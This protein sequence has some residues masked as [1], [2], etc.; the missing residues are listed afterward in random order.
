MAARYRAEKF[1]AYFQAFTNT[2]ASCDVLRERY[3]QALEDSEIV[4]LAIGTRP[5]CVDEAKL[6]LIEAYTATHM[7]W[8]EYGLQSSHNRTLE[9]INRGHNFEDFVRAV[10]MTQGRNILICAHIILGLPGESKTDVLDT[11]RALS[12]LGIDGIKIHSLYILKETP[13][14]QLL[15]AG[16]WVVLEEETYVAWVVAFLERLSPRVVIQRLTGDPD[17]SALIAPS[18]TL[19]KQQTLRRIRD[20]L[21][22]SGTWQGRL[23]TPAGGMKA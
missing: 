19:N 13:L 4:G 20:T 10:R 3:D 11:A 23:C 5:D 8:L 16:G 17:P 12:D 6:D 18:W 2:Y 9:R 21:R 22:S 7:V 1:I 14:A 15:Q